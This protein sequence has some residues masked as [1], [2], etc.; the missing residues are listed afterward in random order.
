MKDE[1]RKASNR[2]LAMERELKK[3]DQFS[4]M[5]KKYF[6]EE[7]SLAREHSDFKLKLEE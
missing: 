6:G 4:T 2:S 7:S 1:A 5:K 3:N